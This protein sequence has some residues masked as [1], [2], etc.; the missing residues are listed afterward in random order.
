MKRASA[1]LSTFLFMMT[2]CGGG[3]DGAA[4]ASPPV[5]PPP[6][7]AMLV[8]DDTNAKDAVRVAYGATVDSMSSG[9]QVGGAGIAGTPD[10][11]FQKPG[12]EQIMA[13]TL[14]KFAAKVPLGPDTYDCGIDPSFGTQTISGEIADPFS[15]LEGTLSP[16]DQI[17]VD[18]MNCDEGLGEILN[19]R[20]E[21]TVV[22]F[23]GDLLVSAAY[24]MVMDVDLV[25]FEVTS[26]AGTILSNGDT[27]VTVDTTGTPL[28][29]ISI[30]GASLTTVTTAGTEVLTNFSTAQTVD[31]SVFPEPYTLTSSGNVDSTQLAGSISFS[32]PVT[33][34]GAGGA[35]PFAGELLV[36]GAN[37]ASIRLIALDAINVRIETDA[38]GDGNVDTTED[39]TWD[40]VALAL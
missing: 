12:A 34:Q 18:F 4:P 36:T 30:S 22:S 6:P 26:A 8:I 7:A 15:L 1:L 14:A 2:A 35:Y 38:D 37:N 20:L 10:G 39:T 28:V 40:D 16:G 3:S 29:A 19:G 17:N 9:D 24:L 13:G 33:F 31:T 11:G 32:T 5:S 21:M 25:D 27:R 23:S